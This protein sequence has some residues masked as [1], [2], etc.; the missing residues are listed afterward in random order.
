VSD[1][2]QMANLDKTVVPIIDWHAAARE[3]GNIRG[4]P[5]KLMRSEEELQVLLE[6]M[7]R[8]Q[9]EQQAAAQA[10]EVAAGVK[11]LAQAAQLA[12][13]AGAGTPGQQTVAA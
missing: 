5:A 13:Q 4:M 12:G 7:A 1:V 11:N 6:Q 9:Q 3:M 10:P 8:Q 2:A